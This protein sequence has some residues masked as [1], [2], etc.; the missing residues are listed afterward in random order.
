MMDFTTEEFADPEDKSFKALSKQAFVGGF[1][2]PDYLLDGILQRR[3]VYSLTAQT[4][5]GKTALALLIARLIGGSDPKAALGRHAAEKGRVVYF[6]G[7]NPDDLRMRVLGDEALCN[8]DNARIWFIPGTFSIEA[9]REKIEAEM[10]R[11]GGVDLVIVDTSAAYFNGKD[12]LSNTEMGAHARLLRTL[13]TLPG[14]PCVLVLCHPVKHVTEPSQLLPRGGGAFLAEV[15]GNLTL[16]KHDGVLLD[17]HHSD[18]L[19]GPGFEPI[20]LRLETITTT[21]LMDKK[22]RLIRTVRAAWI[23][24]AE[25]ARET[26]DARSDEDTL[27]RVMLIP[28]QSIADL[29]VACNWLTSSGEPYKSKVQRVLKRLEKDKLATTKRGVAALT[30][31]GKTAANAAASRF[32]KPCIEWSEISDMNHQNRVVRQKLE[33]EWH[34]TV[35]RTI[36][37]KAVRNARSVCAAAV[38]CSTGGPQRAVSKTALFGAYRTTS[39]TRG[40]K[41][42][43]QGR[44]PLVI[45]SLTRIFLQHAAGL[46]RIA[47]GYRNRSPTALKYLARLTFV[48]AAQLSSAFRQWLDRWRNRQ[49]MGEVRKSQGLPVKD[50]C[51]YVGGAKSPAVRKFDVPPPYTAARWRSCKSVSAGPAWHGAWRARGVRLCA[52]PVCRCHRPAA[53]KAAQRVPK[54]RE[55]SRAG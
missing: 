38:S 8:D 41:W 44:F 33:I 13:T 52:P 14:A 36:I 26:E 19:R 54:A 46:D 20:S 2:P 18:K 37:K 49:A 15:D 1:V 32:S 6:A 23:S 16:W 40:R 22:G 30:D 45:S 24:D 31:A 28:G 34:R 48:N 27:L 10:Q 21:R 29:A 12:E 50:R 35:V 3:F 9:M 55:A 43:D 51:R 7:E 4:G 25:T 11:L 39:F 17:L 42:Y 53:W 5:H 47:S